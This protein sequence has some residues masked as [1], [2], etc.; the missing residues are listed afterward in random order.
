MYK[1]II[2]L[3]LIVLFVTGTISVGSSY[4][5]GIVLIT[6]FEPFGENLVN[7]SIM[8]SDFLNGTSIEG[9]KVYS[10][11]L[12]VIYFKAANKVRNKMDKLSPDFVICLGLDNRSTSIAV[13]R[14]AWNVIAS[15]HPDNEGTVIIFRP[16]AFAPLYLSSTLPVTKIVDDMRAANISALHSLFAGTFVCNEVFYKALLYSKKKNIEVGF[17]HMP[18]IPTQNP[19]GM[20]FEKLAEAVRIA[21]KTCS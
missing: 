20:E 6:G 14:N 17:I 16:I 4:K 5:E 15:F 7:P 11:S 3:L 18:N 2:F 9:K 8:V 1:K 12:P 10:L 19:Y 21:I 13:E